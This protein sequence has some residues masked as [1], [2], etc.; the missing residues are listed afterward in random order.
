MIY[1]PLLPIPF[2]ASCS[3]NGQ[4]VKQGKL[5]AA[6]LGNHATREVGLEFGF[7]CEIIGWTFGFNGYCI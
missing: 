3:I 4:Y 7:L 6:I 5:G 1:F 2:S